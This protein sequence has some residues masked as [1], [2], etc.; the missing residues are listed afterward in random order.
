M[1]RQYLT[2]L[3]DRIT[4]VFT[5]RSTVPEKNIPKELN[6]GIPSMI[7]DSPGKACANFMLDFVD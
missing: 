3:V 7:E 2:L 1:V 4:E 5:S 6:R